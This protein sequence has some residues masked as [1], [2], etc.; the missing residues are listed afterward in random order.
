MTDY[1]PRARLGVA[2]LEQYQEG[3]T[4]LIDVKRMDVSSV[5]DCPAVQAVSLALHGERNSV[6]CESALDILVDDHDAA[7]ALGFDLYLRERLEFQSVGV[8]RDEYDRLT[9]AWRTALAEH[10]AQQ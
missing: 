9:E 10:R 7:A 6:T 3:V 4:D 1:L 2:F 5:Y 8:L